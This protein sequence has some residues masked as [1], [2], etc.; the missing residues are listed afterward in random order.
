MPDVEESLADNRNDWRLKHLQ[1]STGPDAKRKFDLRPTKHNFAKLTPLRFC[2]YL[3][4]NYAGFVACHILKGDVK[5]TVFF[6][7]QI[8]YAT[9][10]NIPFLFRPDA[11]R[12]WHQILC[13]TL[14]VEYV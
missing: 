6:C 5:I 10:Q 14:P 7:S 8:N 2:R 9:R 3:N 4:H 1:F 13:W 12:A 11:F